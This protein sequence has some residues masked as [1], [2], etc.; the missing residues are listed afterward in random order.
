[1][2]PFGQILAC[3]LIL[4]L[5]IASPKCAEAP[6]NPYAILGEV[7]KVVRPTE[8]TRPGPST[9]A[10]LVS[11][12]PCA[13][14]IDVIESFSC[15]T[16]APAAPDL[17][18]RYLFERPWNDYFTVVEWDQRGAGK[19]YVPNDPKKVAPTMNMTRMVEDAEELVAYLRAAYN[20]KKIFVLGHSW[21]TILGLR[22][23]ERRP[24]WL[25]AYIGVG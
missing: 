18:N 15:C 9:L 14:A 20:K 8:S 23:A 3:A 19:T 17:P 5:I 1:M 21:G 13:G 24:D 2:K 10:V 11:G 25:Y 16:V 6:L 7:S 12:L 4:T 22:L